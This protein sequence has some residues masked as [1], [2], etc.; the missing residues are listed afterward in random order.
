MQDITYGAGKVTWKT[1]FGET[2]VAFF[3]RGSGAF[4]CIFM[5]GLGPMLKA[6]FLNEDL[7]LLLCFLLPIPIAFYLSRPREY[8]FDPA[9][10]ELSG[11][12]Y[13]QAVK[14]SEVDR[15]S[16]PAEEKD[17]IVGWGLQLI[18]AMLVYG[19][20][21]APFFKGEYILHMKSGKKKSISFARH[22][23]ALDF[24]HWVILQVDNASKT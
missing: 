15:Y 14:I 7:A 17:V 1:P 2:L 4:F 20:L 23:T 8:I 12:G 16:V 3:R 22:Q 21:M 6:P 13:R 24:Y 9:E 11:P 18:W 10:I 5:L 19:I